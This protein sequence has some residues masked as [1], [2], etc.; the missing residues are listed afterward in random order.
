MRITQI[1]RRRQMPRSRAPPPAYGPRRPNATGAPPSVNRRPNHEQSQ[2]S[3]EN[4]SGSR[5][6][7]LF[8]EPKLPL[9]ILINYSLRQRVASA[10]ETGRLGV[11]A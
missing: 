10:P 6:H 1:F 7:A 5:S 2:L 9:R 8:D 4:K 11:L 3:N